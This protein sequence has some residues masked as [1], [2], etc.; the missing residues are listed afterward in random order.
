MQS[1]VHYTWLFDFDKID[2]IFN[3]DWYDNNEYCIFKDAWREQGLQFLNHS[4]VYV[5]FCYVGWKVV[6]L[7]NDGD[8]VI[9]GLTTFSTFDVNAI[10]N[11]AYQN[12][13]NFTYNQS[14]F[15]TSFHYSV[16]SSQIRMCFVCEL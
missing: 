16:D 13:P 5:T 8:C 7:F 4:N 1:N 15:Q 14:I 6:L 12:E 11:Y 10:L 2:D 3:N 9:N